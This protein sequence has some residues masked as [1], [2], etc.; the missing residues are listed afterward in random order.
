M[1]IDVMCGNMNMDVAPNINVININWTY[2]I[3]MQVFPLEGY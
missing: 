1:S 3:H 2:F